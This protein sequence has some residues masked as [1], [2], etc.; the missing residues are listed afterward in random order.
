M[1]TSTAFEMAIFIAYKFES[2]S[3]GILNRNLVWNGF[4]QKFFKMELMYLC[5]LY[6][7]L[8]IIKI[9]LRFVHITRKY[10]EKFFILEIKEN[11]L[12]FWNFI[13]NFPKVT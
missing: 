3:F 8:N 11:S 4:T 7:Q 9:L 6:S 2:G 10:F 13:Q 1:I 5:F 12:F